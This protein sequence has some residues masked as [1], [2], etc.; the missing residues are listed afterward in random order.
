MKMHSQPHC[1]FTPRPIALLLFL[2]MLVSIFT[3]FPS[4]ATESVPETG[5]KT[6]TIGNLSADENIETEEQVFARITADSRMLHYLD[7]AS[8]RAAGH[9]NRLP[10]E[11]DLN[12]YVF[13]NEDGSRTAYIL[14]EPVKYIDSTGA[15][16]EKDLSLSV[17]QIANAS[18]MAVTVNTGAYT[19][20]A[21][22]TPL[23]FPHDL[24][25][26]V[27]FTY[28]EYTVTLRPENVNA[29]TV[30]MQADGK[31][32][33][34]NAFGAT[35]HLMYTPTLTGLKEDRSDPQQRHKQLFFYP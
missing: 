7:E 10:A 5:T 12:S 24:S 13:E 11:E 25:Q 31:V 3:V 19:V 15:M 6:E 17:G 35:A 21:T 16:R 8:L 28:G 27:C 22:G 1:K 29:S 30:P 23:T 14:A 34:R 18:V 33:Y 26:G 2:S 32:F 20:T 4:Y 9:V